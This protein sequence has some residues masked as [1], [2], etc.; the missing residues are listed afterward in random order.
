MSKSFHVVLRS[1]T[2]H[3]T[4]AIPATAHERRPLLPT[5]PASPCLVSSFAPAS[6]PSACNEC[7]NSLLHAGQTAGQSSIKLKVEYHMESSSIRI[8]S[9]FRI[10][11]P[12]YVLGTLASPFAFGFDHVNLNLTEAEDTLSRTRTTVA[13]NAGNGFI[14]R[15]WIRVP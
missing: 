15:H 6:T 14:G 8:A 10:F 7:I 5:I 3:A 12:I 4:T 11:V 1:F 9:A 13:A 2:K